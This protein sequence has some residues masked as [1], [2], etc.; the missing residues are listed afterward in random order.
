[1]RQLWTTSIMFLLGLGQ[2]SFYQ[3]AA[4]DGPKDNIPD[5]VRQIPPSGIDVSPSDRTELERGLHSLAERI[6]TLRSSSDTRIQSLLPDVEIFYRAVHDALKYNEFFAAGDVKNAHEVLRVGTQ[7]AE[8][9]S[10]GQAPWTEQRGLVVRGFRSKLD[11]TVQPYGLLI[12]ESY[13]FSGKERFRLDLW[14]HGRGETLSENNFIFQRLRQRGNIAPV[15]TIVLHP[16]GRYSNAFKFAGEVDILEAWEHARRHYRIDDDRVA[17][18]GFSMGGAGCWQ[19]AVHYPDRFFVANPGAGF[20]ET[21][22]FLKSFQQETLT[23]IWYE[24]KLWRWYDCPAYAANLLNLPTVAYSGELDIQKQA[25][26]VMEAALLRENISLV[27]VIGPQTK[28]AIHP[29][30]AAEIETRLESLAQRGRQRLPRYVQFT[31]FTLKYNRQHWVEITGLGQHWEPARVEAAIQPGNRLT[32]RTSNVTGLSF[33]MPAGTAPFDLRQAVTVE[34]DGKAYAAPRPAS[35]RSWSFHLWQGEPQTV[36]GPPVDELHKRQNLQGP[37]DDAFMDAFIVV[38][39][40]GT[41]RHERVESWTRGELDHFVEHW[42]RHFRGD[43]IVKDDTEVTAEDIESAHLI[44]FGDPA[45]NRLIGQI[46][47]Q[48][49]IRWTPDDVRIGEQVFDATHHAPALIYPNPL[50]PRRYVVLNSGFTFREF[51]YLNNARQVPKLPDWGVVDVRTPPNSLW[52]GK[53][54][55]ADFFDERWQLQASSRSEK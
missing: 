47:E 13:T 22:E 35:D 18:R 10:T 43:A 33:S 15:D 40:T 21:P 39:P 46:A 20:S 45:S 29:N 24:E 9:L 55:A 28:H 14:L 8:Q 54:V 17:I 38:R 37:I 19:M 31:T 49:P 53:I 51:A 7:R 41:A 5:N 25:A 11:Q 44:L 42:R 34:V 30:S 6:A 36:S 50:N 32:V 23:P 1:M 27:H 4:A 3:T 26:D 48:L 2:L 52:P 16:Y 12:P